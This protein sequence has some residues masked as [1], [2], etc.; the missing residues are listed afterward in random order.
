MKNVRS[1]WILTVAA[2]CLTASTANAQNVDV[3]VFGRPAKADQAKGPH[4]AVWFDEEG[5]HVRAETGG[6]PHT[7]EG[8]IEVE[9]GKFVKVLN[10]ESFDSTPKKKRKG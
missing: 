3:K 6:N 5:W 4:Y 9:G 7:F 8:S 2:L 10:F 1:I